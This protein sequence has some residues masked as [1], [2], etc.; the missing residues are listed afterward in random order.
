M[1]LRRDRWT[2][3][4]KIDRR[5]IAEVM[6]RTVVAPRPPV[7]R[8][9]PPPAR[10]R[11]M[12]RTAAA[13]LFSMPAACV[14]FAFTMLMSERREVRELTAEPAALAERLRE[15]KRGAP[16]PAPAPAALEARDDE[17]LW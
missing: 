7:E 16:A 6:R 10:W 5:G 3:R 13:F 4:A 17:W 14:L 12:P 2:P 15:V 11:M 1:V 9:S 8:R